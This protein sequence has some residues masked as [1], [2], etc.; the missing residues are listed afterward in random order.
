VIKE[1]IIKLIEYKGIPKEEFYI[2]IGMTSASFRGNAKKTPLNSNAIEN[3]LSI[4]PDVNAEWLITGKGSMLKEN[5]SDTQAIEKPY[6]SVSQFKQRG[7]APYYSDLLVSTGQFDL[8]NIEQREEPES[9]IKFPEIEVD[10]WFPVVGCSME[11]EIYAGDI[12]G[13]KQLDSWETVRPGQ[14]L[15]DY[16]SR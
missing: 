13:V 12:V 8:M 4:I 14:N 15:F 6:F 3:I 10:S 16:H 7:Y 2:K 11:P 9:W 1:R 5:S